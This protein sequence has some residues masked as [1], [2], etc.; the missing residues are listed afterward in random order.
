MEVGIDYSHGLLRHVTIQ[1]NVW[2]G[3]V[4]SIHSPFEGHTNQWPQCSI[5][6]TLSEFH[7]VQLPDV[8]IHDAFMWFMTISNNRI[9]AVTK[10]RTTVVL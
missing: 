2:G 10:N 7:I 6:P 1:H 9:R 8:I 3:G 4:A 5:G